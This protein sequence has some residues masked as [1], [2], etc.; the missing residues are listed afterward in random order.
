ML[1]LRTSNKNSRLFFLSFSPKAALVSTTFLDTSAFMRYTVLIFGW[2]LLTLSLRW[3]MVW[4][5]KGNCSK[6]VLF[7]WRWLFL[8]AL[9]AFPED[10]LQSRDGLCPLG[11]WFFDG[12]IGQWGKF[13]LYSVHFG[14]AHFGPVIVGL[15]FD[16]LYGGGFGAGGLLYRF[17]DAG[18]VLV[19][20]PRS[21]NFASL[22]K[23]VTALHWTTWAERLFVGSGSEGASAREGALRSEHNNKLM[24]IC[25]LGIV[26]KL[27]FMGKYYYNCLDCWCWRSVRRCR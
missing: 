11:D 15:E 26:G 24:S 7:L 14:E 1:W 9:V 4:L 21:H 6:F 19:A 17:F 8:G 2:M 16:W 27:S 25:Y 10:D 12:L 23:R 5:Q 20:L 3:C 13:Y 18:A 22:G